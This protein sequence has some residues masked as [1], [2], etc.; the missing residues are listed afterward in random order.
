MAIQFIEE[1]EGRVG[2][3]VN[4]GEGEGVGTEEEDEVSKCRRVGE[5]GLLTQPTAEVFLPHNVTHS[6]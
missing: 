4:E 6:P 5:S 1:K 2:E 3:W